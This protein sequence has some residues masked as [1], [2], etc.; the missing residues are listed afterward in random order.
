MPADA[1]HVPAER[2]VAKVIK[3]QTTTVAAQ[4]VEETGS[5]KAQEA[6]DPTCSKSRKR[7]F[8]EGEGWIVRKV[9]TCY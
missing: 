8:V 2:P 9:T 1:A 6:G 5:I 4:D 7:L 3:S